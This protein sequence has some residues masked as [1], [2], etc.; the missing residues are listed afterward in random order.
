MTTIYLQRIAV[1]N[2]TAKATETLPVATT[3][4]WTPDMLPQNL[5]APRWPKSPARVIDKDC[6]E[7]ALLMKEAGTARH[8]V[9]L[10][11]SDD[12]AAG[13]AIAIGSGAQ[14]ESLWRRTALCHT[15][16]QHFYPLDGHTLL[17]SP[18]VPVVRDTEARGYAWFH[19]P[20]PTL[21]FI[22]CP[23]LKYPRTISNPVTGEKDLQD[24]D[25]QLLAD[26]LHLILRV[27]L[28][29]NNDVIILGAMGC[30]AWR[31]PPAA[32]AAVFAQVLPQYN[33]YFRE[34][35]VAILN[36]REPRGNSAQIFRDALSS[37]K[38]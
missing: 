12:Y 13:G 11:L 30:G 25:K 27:A 35:L 34:I 26:R 31:N 7:L 17:Y 9:V 24:A 32:V 22:A 29:K 36:T 10:N 21:D 38:L 15:Q 4:K 6:I 3:E 33:G 28:H 16:K 14:E 23:A 2:E 37:D 1:F 5:G 8:P 18:T 20:F 19:A